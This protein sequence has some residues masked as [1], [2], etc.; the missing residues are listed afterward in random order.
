MARD[1]L[2]DDDS[3]VDRYASSASS[4]RGLPGDLIVLFVYTVAVGGL[5]TAGSNLSALLRFVFGIPLLLFVP[6]YS[7]L[8]A[9]FPGRPSR[10]AGRVSSFSGL[11]ENF[12][13]IRSI[14]Q[15]GVRWG[16][17]VALSF[18]L[19]LF[20]VPLL[21]LV[22]DLSP[23]PF[24]TGPI[25]VLLVLF[26]LL[27]TLIGALRRLQLSRTQR[28]AVPVGYWIEDFIDGITDSSVDALLNIVLVLSI[29]VATAS[30]AYALGVPKDAT[31]VT[32][33]YVDTEDEPGQI[34][35]DGPVTFTVGEPE[36]LTVGV[37]NNE[38]EPMNYTVVIQLQRIT[39]TGEV[40][41]RTELKRFSTP[42][43]P[44]NKAWQRQHTVTVPISDD[45]L[46][47][48]Y[49]LYRGDAP[50]NPTQQ[51]AYREI[52]LAINA[53]SGGGG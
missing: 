5:I 15:R 33:F 51:N 10:N 38:Q 27:F 22:L 41:S 28:F 8:A 23:F 48:T 19:S 36:Q 1:S 47:L 52:H 6:G 37:R 43:I 9:L 34:E 13:S 32:G 4:L 26:S 24:R 49:L 21:S 2:S 29:L 45:N 3:R 53:T 16:E 39:D 35:F 25:V 7:L 44:P 20:I 11:S 18:G 17:R 46:Q 40:L 42:T 30:M 12:E 50:E 31:T 14:Q